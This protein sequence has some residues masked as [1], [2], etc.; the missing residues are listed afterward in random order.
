VRLGD[1]IG[2]SFETFLGTGEMTNSF[3]ISM[4]G[5]ASSGETLRNVFIT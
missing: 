4:P 3:R 1:A 5:R 2:Y